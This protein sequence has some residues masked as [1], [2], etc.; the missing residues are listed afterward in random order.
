MNH[1][2]DICIRNDSSISWEAMTQT[3]RPTID[4]TRF[5]KML[6]AVSINEACIIANHRKK[7]KE[8]CQ[9]NTMI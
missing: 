5:N 7:Q 8:K 9:N 1:S 6:L 2:S 3:A 4:V